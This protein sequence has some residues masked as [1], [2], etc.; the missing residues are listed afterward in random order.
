MAQPK[1]DHIVRVAED[2]VQ[3]VTIDGVPCYA[4]TVKPGDVLDFDRIEGN[5]GPNGQFNERAEISC[6][7][8]QGTQK[9]KGPYNV[10]EGMLQTYDV[11][12]RFAAGFPA[13]VSANHEWAVLT[14]YHPQDD[15]KSSFKGFGG[16]TFHDGAI[17]FD[18]PSGDGST[19]AK[20]P[21]TADGKTKHQIRMVVKWTSGQSGFAKV[22]DRTTGNLLGRYDGPTLPPGEW[23]YGPMQGYYR[24]GGLPAATV[25]QSSPG[26]PLIDIT[27][28]DLSETAPAPTPTTT[29]PPPA[30]GATT[31]SV[32]E[33]AA[34]LIQTRNAMQ[35]Q[36]DTINRLLGKP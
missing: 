20:M 21:I 26:G 18:H 36:I 15:T 33:Y 23:K 14:Q 35:A 31:A 30:P 27:D 5:R 10:K 11:D 28:G 24:A 3:Q 13:H 4:F 1:I 2:R 29:T 6:A 8:A 19:F 16:A 25:Y 32:Q 17:T 34:C 7:P 22:I 9:Y 12:Y